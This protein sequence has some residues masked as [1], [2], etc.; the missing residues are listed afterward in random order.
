MS[1]KIAGLKELQAKLKKLGARAQKLDGTQNVPVSELLT[2]RFL[3]GCSRFSSV[4]ELFK[5]SGCK[6]E[7]PEDFKAVPDDQWDA[8]I[9][10]N[11]SYSN[12]KEMLGSAAK[13]WTKK[14][15]DL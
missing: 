10:T 7:S 14:R 5:A 8:F 12:W 13:E 15:L 3:E 2:S 6:I 11:T 9:R 4:D 1:V